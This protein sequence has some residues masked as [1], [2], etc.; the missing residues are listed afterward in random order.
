[1]DNATATCTIKCSNGAYGDPQTGYCIPNCLNL[2]TNYYV[3]DFNMLCVLNCQIINSSQY[4][5]NP[6]T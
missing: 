6:L 3:D 1:M 2:T 5:V 4:Y